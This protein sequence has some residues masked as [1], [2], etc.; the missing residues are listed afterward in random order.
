MF[1]NIQPQDTNVRGHKND[2]YAISVT[3]FEFLYG[4]FNG[5]AFFFLIKCPPLE[6][7][8][9]ISSGSHCL[10]FVFIYQESKLKS[11]I[12]EANYF[13]YILKHSISKT[14]HL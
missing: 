10:C 3:L 11:H 2:S 5:T 1:L 6:S 14:I 12:V 13:K 4:F 7:F 8:L 9:I